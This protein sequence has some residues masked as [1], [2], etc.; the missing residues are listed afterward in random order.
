MLLAAGYELFLTGGWDVMWFFLDYGMIGF[1]ILAF[2]GWKL[3]FRT[4]Y[5][6]PG[7]ADISLGG[8]KEEID[9]YEALY[10]ARKPGRVGRL[11]N[12]VFE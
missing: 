7:T 2:I 12:K 8:L 9:Q 1:F 11:I 3:F 4:R 6:R 5:V 10:V